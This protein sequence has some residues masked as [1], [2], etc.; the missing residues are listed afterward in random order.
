MFPQKGFAIYTSIGFLRKGLLNTV[1]N[2][3]QISLGFA[4]YLRKNLLSMEDF[5]KGFARYIR[6]SS[7][8][9]YLLF[10]S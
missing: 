3:F 1:P 4:K 2:I 8:D 9:K 10:D 5:Q 7:N 6:N